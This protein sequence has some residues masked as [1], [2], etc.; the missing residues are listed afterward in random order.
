MTAGGGLTSVSHRQ[1]RPG[2]YPGHPN[3]SII[4]P[5]HHSVTQP[6]ETRENASWA[7]PGQ[8]E[9]ALGEVCLPGSGLHGHAKP[10]PCVVEGCG[11]TGPISQTWGP[12]PTGPGP[13]LQ[14]KPRAENPDWERLLGRGS[15]PRGQGQGWGQGEGEGPAATGVVST[16]RAS[17]VCG[18]VRANCR[19]CFISTSTT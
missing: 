3:Y 9:S 4:D 18:H 16:H 17:G 10:Q 19:T 13:L 11:G 7:R 12:R 2:K 6:N 1:Q 8:E 14:L 15:G 5:C